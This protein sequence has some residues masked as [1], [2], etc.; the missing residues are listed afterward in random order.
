MIAPDGIVHV[1]TRCHCLVH[2]NI[3]SGSNIKF[4][5]AQLQAMI[6]GC[7]LL[8]SLATDVAQRDREHDRHLQGVADPVEL[9][10]LQMGKRCRLNERIE[11]TTAGFDERA[12]FDRPQLAW[13]QLSQHMARAEPAALVGG[14]D[15]ADDLNLTAQDGWHNQ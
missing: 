12:W 5:R 4:S 11:E 7:P 2:L 6:D 10:G 15:H 3:D 9:E 8:E 13:K 14:H 1:V